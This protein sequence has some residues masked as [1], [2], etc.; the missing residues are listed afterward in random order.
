M[1]ITKTPYRISL[2][3][4]GTDMPEWF[5][6]HGGA[7]LSFSIDKYCY[8]LCRDLPPYFDHRF[9]L[10]YSRVETVSDI[11]DIQ[12]PAIREGIRLYTPLRNIEIGHHSDLPARSGIGSS[13]AFAVALVNSLNLL[14]GNRLTKQ[15]LARHAITLEREYIRESVGSQDQVACAMGGLNLIRFGG[16]GKWEIE[17]ILLGISQKEDF[18]D[19]IFLVFSGISRL[20]SDI[21]KGLLDNLETKKG[22]LEALQEIAFEGYKIL[23]KNENLDS[24]G[25]LLKQSWELKKRSNRLA[26]VA[27]VDTVIDHGLEH[28]ALGAKVLGAGGGGFILFWLKSGDKERF[29]S[30][31][32]MGTY[33]PVKID[34][35][36]ATTLESNF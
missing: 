28:G 30:V 9:H 8:L 22:E 33:V 35:L 24:F 13:S 23:V 2:F 26:S 4:G 11:E 10:S 7:V 20:S 19:R 6:R 1:I 18:E 34:S 17:P 31:F 14:N 16:K 3:G 27:E 29:R 15:E 32:K 36:G 21:T 5:E 12:H 25:P